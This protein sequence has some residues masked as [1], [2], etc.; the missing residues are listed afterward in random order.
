MTITAIIQPNYAPGEDAIYIHGADIR[1][2]HNHHAVTWF[3]SVDPPEPVFVLLV[4]S[5]EDE[6]PYR[7]ALA[8]LGLDVIGTDERG[9]WV[10]SQTRPL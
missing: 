7:D 2:P 9:D 6:Q 1:D 5:S 10:L 4:D 3:D 8:N